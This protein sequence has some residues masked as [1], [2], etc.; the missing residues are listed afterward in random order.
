MKVAV[1]AGNSV[2]TAGM[3]FGFV[4]R[5]PRARAQPKDVGDSAGDWADAHHLAS[6]PDPARAEE[7]VDRPAPLIRRCPGLRSLLLRP[8]PT[9]HLIRGNSVIRR[10]AFPAAGAIA[11]A[12]LAPPAGSPLTA[13]RRRVRGNGGAASAV[14]SRNLSDQRSGVGRAHA[15]PC[16][17]ITRTIFSVP[18]EGHTS[19]DGFRD[20]LKLERPVGS[21]DVKR[22]LLDKPWSGTIRGRSWRRA[23]RHRAF[24]IT[25]ERAPILA[26]LVRRYDFEALAPDRVR[27]YARLTTRPAAEIQRR[28]RRVPSKALRTKKARSH[29]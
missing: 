19:H 20:V 3:A 9:R 28:V 16:A 22:L 27:P 26:R 10:R 21:I 17:S 24:F 11:S 29:C 5:T 6:D 15:R 7:L 25:I 8:W 4:R 2:Y 18:L 13:S 12:T 1:G 23:S 14:T